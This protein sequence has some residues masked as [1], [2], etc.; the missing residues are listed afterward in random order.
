MKIEISENSKINGAKAAVHAA[1]LLNAAIKKN[2]GA[3]LLVSTGAS[4]FEMFEKLIT[5]D[6]DWKSVEMFHLDEYVGLP[7]DHPASFRKYLNE[8]FIDHV[9]LKAAY[10]VNGENDVGLA[11]RSLTEIINAAPIDVGLIGIGE[12]GHIAFNDPP[13]DFDTEEAYIVVDLDERCKLQ[14]VG[15]GWFPNVAA[16]PPRAITM[17]VK[18]ILKCKTIISVVPHAVKA[19][20]VYN[21]LARPLSN[22]MPATALKTHPDWNLYVDYDSAAKICVF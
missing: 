9:P 1:E 2:G 15:E 11:V 18:Q 6:V 14:Q 5:L 16:V 21:T 3:R 4:Q 13:A 8:R 20:A 19:D 12:N 7:Y 17:S 22:M 10:F